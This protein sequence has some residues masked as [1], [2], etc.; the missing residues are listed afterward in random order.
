[1]SQPSSQFENSSL[2]WTSHLMKFLHLTSFCSQLSK[3]AYTK[4]SI[5][6]FIS[7]F[8]FNKHCLFPDNLFLITFSDGPFQLALTLS[9]FYLGMLPPSSL[10]CGIHIILPFFPISQPAS[11]LESKVSI[12]LTGTILRLYP[13]PSY[14]FS[15]LRACL[16]VP[17]F[18]TIPCML[19]IQ[20]LPQSSGLVKFACHPLF[21]CF[22]MAAA[23]LLTLYWIIRR[24]KK[25]GGLF[26][27]D[28]ETYVNSYRMV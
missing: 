3:T 5:S 10:I 11:A 4:S 22:M 16:L 27:L 7:T 14:G 8:Q 24:E 9:P 12:L 23:Q 20:F 18:W 6:V 2:A 28:S 19:L 25:K 1:M 13:T 26:I 15:R 21:V 17:T